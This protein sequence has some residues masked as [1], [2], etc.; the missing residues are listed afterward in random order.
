MVLK[1]V[2]RRYDDP[3]QQEE[4][5]NK[6]FQRINKEHTLKVAIEELIKQKDRLVNTARIQLQLQRK[7]GIRVSKFQIRKVAKLLGWNW[8][9]TKSIQPYVNTA[10]NIQK[11]Q[12]WG[13]QLV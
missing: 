7:R 1:K 10:V 12:H 8:R 3:K 11:R 13:R 4:D 2:L 9:R 6:E 5:D